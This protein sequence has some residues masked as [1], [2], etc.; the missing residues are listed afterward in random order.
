MKF[1]LMVIVAIMAAL[2]LVAACGG[3]DPTPPPLPTST[4]TTPV[5]TGGGANATDEAPVGGEVFKANI[6][7]LIHQDVEIPVGTTVEWTS[8]YQTGSGTPTDHSVTSGKP[9]DSDSGAI[10]D[11]GRIT[12]GEIF[13]HT[14]NEVG[15]FPYYCTVHPQFMRK[16]VIVVEK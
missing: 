15:E 8:V 13:T 16:T 7:F 12:E 14:F 6:L 11:S 10:F 5:D 9:G 4:P 2:M 1:P 3:D